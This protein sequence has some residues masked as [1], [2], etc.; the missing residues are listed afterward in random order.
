MSRREGGSERS[1]RGSG[2]CEEL[3]LPATETWIFGNAVSRVAHVL[4]QK[5]VRIENIAKYKYRLPH[6]FP[7]PPIP[8]HVLT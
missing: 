7:P 4:R 3:D 6:P 8:I 2:Q 1:C 5:A